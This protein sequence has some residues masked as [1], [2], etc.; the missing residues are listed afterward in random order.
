MFRY[1]DNKNF[2]RFSWNVQ[3]GLRRLEKVQNGVPTVLAKD[4]VR[5]VVGSTYQLEALVQGSVL[6]VLIDGAPVF[7]VRDSSFNG[8][9]I[10]LYS[11]YNQGSL[12]DDV[13]V[14]DLATG[15]MLLSENFNDGDFTGWTIID[16]G[17]EEGLSLWSA[18]S[19]ALVQNRDI[20]SR[21]TGQFGTYALY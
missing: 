8:G 12:F 21:T 20:G 1:V 15:A 17:T 2:Y 5:Y 7:S 13:V 11:G 6:N 4:S 16:E 18:K 14:Q 9:T 3:E 10:A 19:G